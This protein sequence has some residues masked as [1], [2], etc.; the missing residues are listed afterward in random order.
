MTA[1]LLALVLLV[2]PALAGAAPPALEDSLARVRHEWAVAAFELSPERR[3]AALETLADMAH[4]LARRYPGEPQALAWEGIVLASLAESRG[5]VTGYFAAREARALLHEV[6]RR[7][8]AVLD[9]AGYAALGMLYASAPGWPISFG[10]CATA[11]SYLEKALQT[12]PGS[13]EA[14]YFYGGFLLRQGHY[15]EATRHLRLALRGAVRADP[16]EPEFHERREI[17]RILARAERRS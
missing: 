5:P 16:V 6:E 10:D 9:G 12:A 8:A 3:G 4:R 2:L 14:H 13:M 7:D 11:R 15:D 1:R 17:R